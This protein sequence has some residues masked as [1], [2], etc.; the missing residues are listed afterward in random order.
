MIIKK[1]KEFKLIMMD[2][3]LREDLNKMFLLDKVFLLMLIKNLLYK[4]NGGKMRL[5]VKKS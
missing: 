3:N 4:E 5:L 2:Q 1:E